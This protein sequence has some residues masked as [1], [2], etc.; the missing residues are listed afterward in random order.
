VNDR[1]PEIALDDLE[2]DFATVAET[3]AI[4]RAD[5]RTIRRRCADGTIPAV[6]LGDWRIP[7]RWLREAA[8][9]VAA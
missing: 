2:G 5:Q 8:G 4:T 3:A 7:V 9:A 1:K 6:K